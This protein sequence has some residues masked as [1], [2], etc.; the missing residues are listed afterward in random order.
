MEYN[1]LD[2]LYNVLPL[3][4]WREE[5][6]GEHHKVYSALTGTN[7][8]G[9]DNVVDMDMDK[10]DRKFRV[11]EIIVVASEQKYENFSLPLYFHGIMTN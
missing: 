11:H 10:V 3:P 1:L 5:F 6:S 8:Y 9:V 4:P 7:Q 2:P